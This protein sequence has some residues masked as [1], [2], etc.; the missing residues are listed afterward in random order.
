MYNAPIWFYLLFKMLQ[1]Y[2]K[3][4]DR[5]EFKNNNCNTIAINFKFSMQQLL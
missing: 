5:Y 2:Q 1:E 3:I 4:F